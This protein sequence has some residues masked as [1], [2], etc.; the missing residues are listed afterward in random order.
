M[1]TAARLRSVLEL[2]EHASDESFRFLFFDRRR[3][4]AFLERRENLFDF[5][6]N[7]EAAGGRFRKDQPPVHQHVELTGF[8]GGDFRF[9]AER[10]IQ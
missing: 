5:A 2:A 1:Q 6:V 7:R 3:L 9:F 8:A 10:G 4:A